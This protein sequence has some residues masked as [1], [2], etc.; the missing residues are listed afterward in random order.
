MFIVRVKS[1]AIPD[2]GYSLLA[3]NIRQQPASR[4]IRNRLSRVHHSGFTLL[5]ITLAVAILAMMSLAIFRFVQSNLVALRAS[6]DVSTADARYDGLRDLL[7]AEWQSL[8]PVRGK[9]TGEPFKLN[10]RQRDQI[11]WSCSAGPGLLTRYAPGEFRVSLRLQP[12]DKKRDRLDLGFLR[13]PKDDP[14]IG[15]ENETWVPLIKNVGSLQI[16]YF[17]PGLRTWVDRWPN[18]PPPR[19]VKVIVGRTD[20]AVPWEAIIPLA[21]TPLPWTM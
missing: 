7:T 16:Q 3:E 10:D 18:K 8:P 19:L 6:S 15:H 20:A 17:D 9:M 21:R 12:D 11:T 13:K 4:S 14:G 5:E 1:K 2:T